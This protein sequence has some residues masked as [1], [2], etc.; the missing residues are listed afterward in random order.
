M[1]FCCCCWCVCVCA[2][3]HS[4]EFRVGSF[5]FRRNLPRSVSQRKTPKLL[6]F[7]LVCGHLPTLPALSGPSAGC[8]CLLA[9]S[10]PKHGR[11]WIERNEWFWRGVAQG[12]F[13]QLP[14]PGGE[15]TYTRLMVHQQTIFPSPVLQ[16]F[17]TFRLQ[18]VR[19]DC[20]GSVFVC[21]ESNAQEPVHL[22]LVSGRVLG[23]V[24]EGLSPY[25][26]RAILL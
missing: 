4:G 24:L 22:D 9:Q 7:C 20:V 13:L 10:F 17:P 16:P 6:F 19:G 23:R 26:P 21:G 11:D 12:F 18:C 14:I 15:L 25:P 2:A 1:F 3:Q 8:I 5:G